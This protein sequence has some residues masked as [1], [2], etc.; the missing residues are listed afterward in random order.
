M[1]PAVF[2]YRPIIMKAQA[3]LQ[4]GNEMRDCILYILQPA[5]GEWY[6]FFENDRDYISDDETFYRTEALAL[7]HF[8]SIDGA[9]VG[10]N[11]E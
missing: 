8:K 6:W 11:H 4:I 2:R 1:S 9:I 5:N 10:D 7:A 3:Q